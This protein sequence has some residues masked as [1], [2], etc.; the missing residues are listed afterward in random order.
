MTRA[1]SNIDH[2]EIAKFRAMADLWW[3]PKG[4]F[5]ALHD[6]N[7]VRLAYVRERAG[8][9]GKDVLDVGCGGGLMA[10]AMARQAARVTGIDM[11]AESLAVADRHARQ[12]GV[13]V[14]Y[15]QACA[16]TWSVHHPCAYDLVTCME[17][18]EH[19]PDPARLVSAC[20]GM[21]R[22]GGSVV[23]GTINRTPLAFMLVIAV[24]EY[25]L[26]IVRKGT[27]HYRKFVRPAELRAW[28]RKAGLRPV[29][30]TGLQYIPY[31]GVARR[32]K[33][34]RINYLLHLI[35]G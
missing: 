2:R 18:V 11:E 16:E 8:L 33:T 31:L 32:C 28:G 7:P 21:L 35:K 24:A 9:S 25:L 12:A 27:H 22:P 3:Q 26:G 34:V 17:L 15:H 14:S 6:I 5:K 23:I 20:A 1:Q 29:D 4:E 19:V 13:R 30:Q 10:E